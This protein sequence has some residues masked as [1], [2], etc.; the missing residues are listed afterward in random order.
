MR[1]KR[2]N[3]GYACRTWSGLTKSNLSSRLLRRRFRCICRWSAWWRFLWKPLFTRSILRPMPFCVPYHLLLSSLSQKHFLSIPVPF[4]V[5]RFRY[6]SCLVALT[7]FKQAPLQDRVVYQDRVKEVSVGRGVLVEPERVPTRVQ[8]YER[9]AAPL[10]PSY[11]RYA[12]PALQTY[13]RVTVPSVQY[14]QR[15]FPTVVSYSD[16]ERERSVYG[17][18]GT[19]SSQSQSGQA[20]YGSYGTSTRQTLSYGTATLPAQHLSYSR[21]VEA[22]SGAYVATTSGGGSRIK[23]NNVEIMS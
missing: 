15:A 21:G 6:C 22:S 17:S 4:S 1:Q 14:E 9:V 20:I 16:R 12:A 19:S 23:G 18:H 11:E 8:S 10:I 13:E 5:E 7:R 3:L 2:A